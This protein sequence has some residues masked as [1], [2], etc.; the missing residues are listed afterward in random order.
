MDIRR[1]GEP[2]LELFFPRWSLPSDFVNPRMVEPAGALVSCFCGHHVGRPNLLFHLARRSIYQAREVHSRGGHIAIDMDGPQ[3]WLL[4][5]R[6]T[7]VPTGGAGS[8]SMV[9]LG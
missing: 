7:A 9:P 8:S 1:T 6:Q 3:R 5:R 4:Y 2:E